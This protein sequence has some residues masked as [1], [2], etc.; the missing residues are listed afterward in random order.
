[1]KLPAHR[2]GLAGHLP[3]TSTCSVLTFFP[4]TLPLSPCLP[5]GRRWGEGGVRGNFKYLWLGFLIIRAKLV[6]NCVE[7]GII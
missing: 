4:L 2:A 1:V 3:V 5:A 7:Y 6:P